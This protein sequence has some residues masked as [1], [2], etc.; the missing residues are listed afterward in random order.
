MRRS[1]RSLEHSAGALSVTVAV[2]LWWLLD[3]SAQPSDGRLVV[4][5][6]EL[7]PSVALALRLPPV[8]RFV[9]SVDELVRDALFGRHVRRDVCSCSD[10][11][12]RRHRRV[13]RIL[14]TQPL[15]Y[16]TRHRRPGSQ[17]GVLDEATS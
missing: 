15:S 4:A 6:S 17:S 11:P 16:G 12:P 9:V 13:P 7:L 2:L 14:A 3:K 8:R 10:G 1:R 5:H